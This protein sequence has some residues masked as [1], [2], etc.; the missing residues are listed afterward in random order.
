MSNDSPA[1]HMVPTT[2]ATPAQRAAIE[3]VTAWRRTDASLSP[4]I[5]RRGV[6]MLYKRSLH[7]ARSA[8]PWLAKVLEGEWQ[9]GDFAPLQAALERQ[10]QAEAMAAIETLPRIFHD[11]LSGL[12]GLSLTERLLRSSQPD[13]FSDPA[14]RDDS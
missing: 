3:A 6:A 1:L 11:Q 9:P 8:H 12:I 5:G 14:A 4:I 13:L 2:D 10:S 7:L